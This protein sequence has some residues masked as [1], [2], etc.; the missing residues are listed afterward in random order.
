MG[1]ATGM[2]AAQESALRH[3]P[4]EEQGWWPPGGLLGSTGWLGRGRARLG[5]RRNLETSCW[6]GSGG[7]DD[8]ALLHFYL[9]TMGGLPDTE[10]A[11]RKFPVWGEGSRG[12]QVRM[13][14]LE[15]GYRGINRGRGAPSRVEGEAVFLAGA[16]GGP[17]PARKSSPPH[18]S[19]RKPTNNLP[20][21]Q[22]SAPP[23]SHQKGLP[24]VVA[25][26]SCSAVTPTPG[27]SELHIG[28]ARGASHLHWAAW[29]RCHSSCA[30]PRPGAGSPPGRWA[31]PEAGVQ[32]WGGGPR[33]G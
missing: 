33:R 23:P 10:L 20:S 29:P 11:S 4:P 2:A 17:G 15:G 6:W 14:P 22:T 19:P 13:K 24:G 18:C 12:A 21:P 7:E 16:P 8:L 3:G 5:G 32:Q 26:G 1:E 25:E 9:F 27:L 28:R 31:P 30:A